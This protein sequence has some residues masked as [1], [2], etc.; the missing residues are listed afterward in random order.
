MEKTQEFY[1]NLLTEEIRITQKR[2]VSVKAPKGLYLRA[3]EGTGVRLYSMI[4]TF[5]V[6]G[7]SD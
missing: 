1:D 7:T 3:D 5:R 4:E 6:L 2:E